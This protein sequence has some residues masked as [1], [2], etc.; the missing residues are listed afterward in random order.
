MRSH[1]NAALD[2]MSPDGFICLTPE[3]GQAL[4]RGCEVSAHPGNPEYTEKVS[5]DMILCQQI[6]SIGLSGADNPNLYR[7]LVNYPEPDEYMAQEIGSQG[8]GITM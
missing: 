8:M 3:E 5:A 1:P 4:L 2:I 6:S 7:M